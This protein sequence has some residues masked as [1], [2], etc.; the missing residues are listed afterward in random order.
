MRSA[1]ANGDSSSLGAGV[2][3]G[4]DCWLARLR[5]GGAGRGPGGP[6]VGV[7]PGTTSSGLASGILG[8]LFPHYQ[9]AIMTVS[10]SG[11]YHGGFPGGPGVK[12]LHT[13]EGDTGLIPNQEAKILHVEGQLSLPTKTKTRCSQIIFLENKVIV[14]M[15]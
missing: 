14:I 2:G 6:R 11:D 12:N 13:S 5:G 9:M 7:P 3:L 8:N 4:P 15:K 1:F 10:A